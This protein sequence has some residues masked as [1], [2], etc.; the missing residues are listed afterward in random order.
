MAG[1]SLADLALPAPADLSSQKTAR[2]KFH[3]HYAPHFD[4]F[5]QSAGTDLLDQLRFIA[6]QGFSALED[7]AMMSR[8]NETQESIA[9]TMDY[10]GLNMG[11]F[12]A[13]PPFSERNFVLKDNATRQ[14][15]KNHIQQAV[16]TA[17]R[18]NTKWCLVV[19]GQFDRSLD[20]GYQTANVIDNLKWCAEICAP[21]G[22]IMVLEPLNTRINHPGVF[23]TT[24]AQA[25]QICQ[26]VNSPSC[27]ILDDLYHQQI[28]EG[29]LIYNIDMAWDQIA[30]FHLG[31]NP[32]RHEPTTGE[33]NYKN[34]FR[35]LYQKG[36]QGVLG[37]EHG[38][39]R[40]GRDGES[41]VIAAYRWCDNFET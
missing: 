20:W 7:N 21:S 23:L 14:M 33:I 41:A 29:N 11:E 37:M 8:P 32:G 26:A 22:A 3:L 25:Y 27:K 24:I 17:Q 13:S 38:Q 4:Q 34:I 10:L 16:E 30:Y 36:Y 35:H 40:P 31:D 5:M 15:L 1:I 12:V 18:L 39:S 19:P 28:T 6:D 9:R 2:E